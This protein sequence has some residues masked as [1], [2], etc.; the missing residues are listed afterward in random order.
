MDEWLVCCDK[1]QDFFADFSLLHRADSL[2][3]KL[4]SDSVACISVLGDS[5]FRLDL[6]FENFSGSAAI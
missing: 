3:A 6:K 1:R 4:T 2:S 5:P